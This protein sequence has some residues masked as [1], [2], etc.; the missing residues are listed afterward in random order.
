MIA[1][2]RRLVRGLV[3]FR[4]SRRFLSDVQEGDWLLVQFRSAEGEGPGQ[5]VGD[6]GAGQVAERVTAAFDFGV[7]HGQGGGRLGRLQLVVIAD[8]DVHAQLGG[9]L[10]LGV[11]RDAAVHGDD[12][13][14]ARRRELFHRLDRE[15]VGLLAA[16]HPPSRLD[17]R[18]R[19]SFHHEGGGRYAIGVAVAEDHHLLALVGGEED[20]IDRVFHGL[21]K[22]GIVQ[23]AG[24]VLQVIEHLTRFSHLAARED[25]GG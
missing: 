1:R 17:L 8:D 20:A 25:G 7:D 22:K 23:V 16:G 2:G 21:E 15:A 24:V 5:L 18:R 4:G 6:A 13:A 3:I 12:Q 10:N 9:A 19:E 14:A 11:V